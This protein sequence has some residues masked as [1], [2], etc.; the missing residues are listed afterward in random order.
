MKITV[1]GV[2]QDTEV[3]TL[4]ALLVALGYGD[5]KIATAINEV[6][7]PATLREKQPLNSGDRIEI[8]APRQ[9]G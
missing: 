5:S 8:V 3:T 4:G 9:G 1:N 6:F 2:A 7:V